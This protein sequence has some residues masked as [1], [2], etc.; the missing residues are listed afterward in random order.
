M[1]KFVAEIREDWADHGKDRIQMLETT[2]LLKLRDFIVKYY[3]LAQKGTTHAEIKIFDDETY[4]GNII[5]LPCGN[6]AIE[7]Y[8]DF[9]WTL[10]KGTPIENCKFRRC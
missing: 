5:Y 4:C 9:F 3:K 2:S 6:G 7:L 10:F 8:A 1:V